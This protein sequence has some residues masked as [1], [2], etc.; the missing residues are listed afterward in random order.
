MAP[1][2]MAA[3]AMT[4]QDRRALLRCGPGRCGWSV[5]PGKGGLS[6]QG[7]TEYCSSGDK[8]LFDRHLTTCLFVELAIPFP[9]NIPASYH[10]RYLRQT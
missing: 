8:Q 1:A 9:A 6:V 2:V 10:C 7:Q 3:P 5:C 4:N